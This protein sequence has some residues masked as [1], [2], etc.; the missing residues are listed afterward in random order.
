MKR[1]LACPKCGGRKIGHLESL[2][3]TLGDETHVIPRRVGTM[4]IDGRRTRVGMIEA[5][6]CAVCGYLE[7]YVAEIE[8]VPLEE[9]EGFCW[10]R[11]P[12][13]PYR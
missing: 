5:Y 3:D 8:R 11:E 4:M 1:N 13:S 7:E 9:L 12:A 2:P 6:V 10:V